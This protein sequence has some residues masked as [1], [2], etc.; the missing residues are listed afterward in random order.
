MGSIGYALMR[1]DGSGPT[2]AV[3]FTNTPAA[4][5][6]GSGMRGMKLLVVVLFALLQSGCATMT[7]GDCLGGNWSRIG[8][9]DGVAGYPASRLGNHEQA[10]MAHGV[11]VDARTYMEARERGLEVYCTPYR[12]FTAAAN[13]QNYAGV[14]PGYLEPGFLAGFSDGRFVHDAKRYADDVSS[15]VSAI[16]YRV[17]KADKDIDKAR[18]RLDQT[19]S[20]E[21][22]KRIEREIDSL[23]ADIRRADE[24]LAHARR[25]EDMARRELDHVSRRF[26]P[27]YGHW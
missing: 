24:A 2:F 4:W 20:G 9:Q 25:R 22:R 17:R 27:I 8:Y 23:R 3:A 13:G 19:E 1:T 16:Q 26:A 5:R 6:Q 21:E 15:D 12:G 7:Q 14:C 10:C 11:G 18:K